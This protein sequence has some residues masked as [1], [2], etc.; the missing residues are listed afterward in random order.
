MCWRDCKLA[1]WGSVSAISGYK[2]FVARSRASRAM[3]YKLRALSDRDPLDGLA[4]NL[5]A[6]SSVRRLVV[7]TGSLLRWTSP[8][9]TG[10]MSL[11]QLALNLDVMEVIVSHWCSSLSKPKTLPVDSIKREAGVPS[12]PT[13]KTQA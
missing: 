5:E 12:N 9:L 2:W 4:E 10:I 3:A 1:G 8:E 6:S 7:K 13:R 11:D